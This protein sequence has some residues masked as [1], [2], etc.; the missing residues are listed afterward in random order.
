MKALDKVYDAVVPSLISRLEEY[1]RCIKEGLDAPYSPWVKRWRNDGTRCALEPIS[2]RNG[3]SKRPYSGVNW[4]ILGLLSEYKSVDWFTLNQ[5]KKLTGNNR[6]IPEGAWDTSEEII[7]FKVNS[8]T[9]KY[10]DEVHFPLAKTYR[11]WNREEIP[12]LPDP[13]PD[14]KPEEFDVRSEID[15][16][17]K[18]INLKGGI[19]YGGDRAFYRPSDD[20][21]ACPQE[22]AFESWEEFEATKAHETV[23]ATGAKHRLDRTKGKRFGDEAYAYEELVAELGAAMICS[24]V[25]IPLERLQHTQYIHGWLKRLKSDKKFLFNAAADAGRAFNYLIDEHASPQSESKESLAC[26]A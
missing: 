6:P 2:A 20:G 4:V 15:S 14:V 7:F 23:H 8:F 10:G 19:H 9:D 16:Y 17:I 21:I 5:L 25:G 22:S 1:D 12:G 24:H 11:V 26:A 13:V 18:K 3:V